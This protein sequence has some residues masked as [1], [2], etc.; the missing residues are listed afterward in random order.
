MRNIKR[1]F[2]TYIKTNFPQLSINT[3]MELPGGF[4]M[5]EWEAGQ[6]EGIRF[7]FSFQTDRRDKNKFTYNVYWQTSPGERLGTIFA[8]LSAADGDIRISFLK[9]VFEGKKP[10]APFKDFWWKYEENMEDAPLEECLPSALTAF[11]E[12]IIPFYQDMIVFKQTGQ[13]SDL[14]IKLDEFIQN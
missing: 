7:F 11:N 10:S 13:K 5:Y 8:P 6:H 3:S 12:W 14:L 2:K 9:H 4:L 1:E